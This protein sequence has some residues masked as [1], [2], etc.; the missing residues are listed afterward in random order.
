MFRR[1]TLYRATYAVAI[2]LTLTLAATAKWTDYVPTLLSTGAK[3]SAAAV[4]EQ[5]GTNV[6]P[7]LTIGSCESPSI[8]AIEV[9]ATLGTVGPTGYATLKAAFDAINAGTHQGSISIDVCGNTVETA[10]AA[11]N[12]GAVAPASYTD[13]TVR[14]AGGARVI[15]GSIVGAVVKLNGADNVLIDGRQ[16]GTGTA[17]DLTVRNNNVASATAAIWL[18]SVAAGNGA[19]N[20]SIRYLEIACGTDTSSSS[21]STF[22]IL[23]SGTTISTT[24]NGLDNDGNSFQFNRIVKVRYGIVTRG[25]TTDLNINPVV[26]DNV[27]GPSA[28]GTE[29]INKTGIFMQ[30]DTGAVVSRNTVQFV[31]CL[32]PQACT[33]A[34]RMGIAIGDE[35]W[36]TA[37]GTL[38]SNNYTVTKNNVHD[39]VEETTFSAVGIRLGTTGGGSATNNLVANNFIYNVRA[40]GTAGDQSVGL[41]ISGG[42]TD[43]VVFNSISMI[44]DVDPG[45]AAATSNYGSGIRIG[46]ASSASH[47]NLT[48]MNNSVY[49]DLSSSSAPTVRYYAISGPSNTYSFGTGGENYNN[50]YI[51]PLNTQLQT[52][53]LGTASGATLTTQFAS[54][55]NWQTAYT[56]AQD[57]NSIQADPL[58]V[59]NTSDLHISP[60]S[61]NQGTGTA[62]AGVADDIDG[63]VRPGTPDIGADE[64]VAPVGPGTVQFS[65]ATFIGNEG[66]T[67]TITVSR[68]GGTSGSISVDYATS[69]GTGTAGVCGSGGDYVTTSGTLTFADGET[70]KSFTVQLC[71]DTLTEGSETVSLTLSNPV[72]TTIGGTNPA[73]LNIGDLPPGVLQFSSTAYTGNENTVVT[74]TVTRTAGSFGSVSVDYT[75]SNGSATAGTCGSGGDYVTASGTL[76]WA[77]GDT[78]SKTFTVTLCPDGVVDPS[79]TVNL[80]L[81][82]PGGGAGIGANNPAVLTIGDVPPP[83]SGSYNVGAGETYTSLT[84]NGGIFEALNLSGAVGNVTI[85]ITS[86]L[87]AETGTHRL[88][89]LLG[90]FTVAIQPGGGAARLVTGS[91]ATNCLIDLNGADNVMIDGLNSSGNSLTFRNT[92]VSRPTVCMRNDANDNTVQ[93]STIEGGNT[94]T[95]S[96]TAGVLSIFD[97]V[98]TGNDDNTFTNNV[99]RDRTDVAGLPARLFFAD[100][101]T[102]AVNSNTILS[103]NQIKNFT[104]IAILFTSTGNENSSITGNSIFEEAQRSTAL[105]G[106]EF[107][108][109]G[110]NLI[111]QNTIRNLNT[112]LTTTGITLDDAFNTTVTRNHIHSF[113]SASGNISVLTGIQFLG[114]STLDPSVTITNNMISIVPTAST[115]QLI[116]GIFDNAFGGDTFLAYFN[117]VVVGG[118]SSGTSDSWACL[119]G[120]GAPTVHALMDN[121][122][123][124]NRSGGGA[125]HFA[126]GDQ[127]NGTGTFTSDYNIFVG[128][129]PVTAANFFDKGTSTTG[130]PVDFATWQGQPT[131]TRDV[132]SQASNPGGN[133]TVANM[134][135]S[136]TDLHLNTTGTNPALNAGIA[137]GGVT[138]D[139][140]NHMRPQQSGPE[141]GADEILAPTAALVSISGRV[142]DASGNGIRNAVLVLEGGGLE[143]PRY[144]RTGSFGYYGFDGLSNGTYTVSVF[145]KRF[146]FTTPVRTFTLVDDITGVDFVADPQ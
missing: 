62:I 36:S 99:I 8:G 82:N 116:R 142:I 47:A 11:L 32:D 103:N 12:S 65:S 105:T 46:V 3:T 44:G 63:D 136:E 140:D 135:I 95:V 34:D 97:G 90:G 88:N 86:D 72:G 19:S 5:A 51:N 93:N 133:Y 79:E 23:M 112:S 124:N 120:G 85:N 50:Y 52:G 1:L 89:E 42:H 102:G 15:E 53:G 59:S 146:T 119:R 55:A 31:G 21:N 84:N 91:S 33:G 137:A 60:S 68:L 73:T 71:N 7:M 43:R 104:G 125:D 108:S 121:I 80:T 39:I 48:L 66:T 83:L 109:L 131:P 114:S 20:N 2:A 81:S 87:T 143:E 111:S 141:I 41:G 92:N 10:T 37:P 49:M 117:T 145:T 54:L 134:F 6:S 78:T 139:F 101:A 29:Q 28:F 4:P 138:T 25:T 127:S 115:S 17:R 30:A 96:T 61:P 56:P 132:N 9:E 94:T 122:C 18:A 67:A 100:G 13:V 129:G 110:T 113:S 98:T 45:A 76:T 107:N 70:S 14:P 26:T 128:T 27:I 16:G 74:I 77:D 130:T 64:V 69:N 24:S 40:N 35:S 144:I 57:A 126:V 106:I 75:T 38:T 118:V 58:Y 123:F 22:G